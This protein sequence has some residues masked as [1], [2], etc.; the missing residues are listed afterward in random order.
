MKAI[1]M[2]GGQGTRLRPLTCTLPKPML[3]IATRPVIEYTIELLKKHGIR[4][5]GIT[6]HYLPEVIRSH[7]GTGRD[8]EVSIEYFTETTPLGT[9][10]SIK[11]AEEFLSDTFIVMSG[12]GLCDVDLTKAIQFHNANNAD[13]TVVLTKTDTPLEYGAVITDENSRIVRLDEKPTW[14]DVVTDKINTGIYIINRDVLNYVPKDTA[15]DFSSEFF[16]LL[17]SEQKRIFGYFSANYWCDIGNIYSYSKANSDVLNGKV[18]VNM[19]EGFNCKGGICIGKNVNIHES[20]KLVAPCMISH[21]TTIGEGCV[22][23]PDV[24]ICEGSTISANTSI[25][26][27]VIYSNVY[28]DRLCELRGCVISSGCKLSQGVKVFEGSC[29][30]HN[31]QIGGYSTITGSASVWPYKFIEENCTVSENIIWQRVR[32]SGYFTNEAIS[33]KINSQVTNKTALISA[34]AFAGQCTKRIILGNSGSPAAKMLCDAARS[35]LIS[36]GGEVIDIGCVPLPCV[37]YTTRL[38][39]ASGAIYTAEEDSVASI[40]FIDSNGSAISTSQMRKITSALNNDTL[41]YCQASTMAQPQSFN[42]ALEHYQNHIFD[43][44]ENKFTEN[45]L[46]VGIRHTK[47]LTSEYLI[48]LLMRLGVKIEVLDSEFMPEMNCDVFISID[49]YGQTLTIYDDKRIPI[50]RHVMNL[51]L[52]YIAI[53]TSQSGYTVADYSSPNAVDEVARSSNGVV[54]RTRSG[55]K[56]LIEEIVKHDSI[57]DRLPIGKMSMYYDANFFLLSLLLV[58]QRDNKTPNELIDSLPAVHINEREVPCPW[59]LRCKVLSGLSGGG[60]VDHGGIKMTQKYGWSLII[61]DERR[62]YIKI[63]SEAYSA[64]YAE[65]L[66]DICEKKIRALFKTQ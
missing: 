6:L 8:M 57:P 54:I 49:E 62:P 25:K 34:Q 58:C 22:I 63:F 48:H 12:D 2:A 17:M 39:G 41:C 4:D 66:T 3:E 10:G 5:I 29:I 13:V 18:Q 56:A 24:I 55:T 28:I 14:S 60:K 38:L 30:G 42:R 26:S 59:E 7:L 65:E 16:P 45:K 32:Y 35:G 19:P 44:F 37:R 23:G 53:E 27:S 40:Y 21:N 15:F 51:L 47:S 20:A 11:Q 43:M 1:I 50:D 9:A 46:T 52:N 36:G 33:G 64:E 31:A 61:P